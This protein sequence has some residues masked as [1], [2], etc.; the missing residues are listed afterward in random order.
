MDASIAMYFNVLSVC[1]SHTVHMS[2]CVCGA[3]TRLLLGR[4]KQTAC[5]RARLSLRRGIA[6]PEIS[7]SEPHL[8]SYQSMPNAA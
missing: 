4:D 1:V 5:S 3:I 7:D 8:G 6:K 2:T